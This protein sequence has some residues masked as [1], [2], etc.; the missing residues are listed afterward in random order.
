MSYNHINMDY[1]KHS[2]PTFSCSFIL[3]EPN[4]GPPSIGFWS[5]ERTEYISP[6]HLTR[7]GKLIVILSGSKRCTCSSGS[8]WWRCWPIEI[9]VRI[10]EPKHARDDEYVRNWFATL[11]PRFVQ[12][13]GMRYPTC[14]W[15]VDRYMPPSCMLKYFTYCRTFICVYVYKAAAAWVSLTV[16]SG[17]HRTTLYVHLAASWVSV[18]YMCTATYLLYNLLSSY[19]PALTRSRS[20]HSLTYGQAFQEVGKFHIRV[21]IGW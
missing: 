8:T 9:C 3:T 6:A 20:I 15:C 21:Y 19:P 11:C 18:T 1:S 2:K 4:T 17:R 7:Y 14:S 10:V 12:M 13:A 16:L 5:R